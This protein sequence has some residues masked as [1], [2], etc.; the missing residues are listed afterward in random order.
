V[1]LCNLFRH[2]SPA[3]HP[4]I[5]Y[6]TGITF[7]CAHGGW[8]HVVCHRS[9]W[10]LYT[11]PGKTRHTSSGSLSC[12][13]HSRCP[14][15]LKP[16]PP[17]PT[18]DLLAGIAFLRLRINSFLL[19]YKLLPALFIGPVHLLPKKNQ[20]HQY[21]FCCIPPSSFSFRFNPWFSNIISEASAVWYLL[22]CHFFRCF[23]RASAAPVRCRAGA[24]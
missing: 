5:L 16:L 10:P 7:D 17:C 20:Q 21:L 15:R 9:L 22:N 4:L 6:N 3:Q 1:L 19:H 2:P 12:L 18:T 8:I 13:A 11:R 14:G 23:F 24:I